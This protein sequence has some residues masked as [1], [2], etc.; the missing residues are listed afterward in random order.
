M[1][2]VMRKDLLSN[3]VPETLLSWTTKNDD[4]LEEHHS[5]EHAT[6]ICKKKKKEICQGI[7]PR[8]NTQQ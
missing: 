7:P 4:E 6:P 8:I 1:S 5:Q 3:H 2:N